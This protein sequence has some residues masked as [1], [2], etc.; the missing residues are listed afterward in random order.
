MAFQQGLSGLNN[1]SKALDVISNN[2]AN[3]STVGFKGGQA[4]FSDAFAAS[5]GAGGASAVGIGAQLAGVQQQF[6]QGG[7]SNSNNPLDIAINGG[8]SSA[9]K[10]ALQMRRQVIPGT[11]NSTWMHRGILLTLS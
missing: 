5:L 11:V 3:A 10:R 2:I 1:S 8:G 9:F 7:I 4:Q 6:S